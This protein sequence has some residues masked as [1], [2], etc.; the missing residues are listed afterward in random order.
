MENS[1][2]AIEVK[3]NPGASRFEATVDGHLSVADYELQGDTMVMTHTAVPVALRGRGIAEK[4]VRAA[5]AHARGAKLRVDPAC[6]Y[7]AT[8]MQRNPEFQPLRR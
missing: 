8:F 4:L 7:V 6:S 5:L 1:P 2:A 3:H